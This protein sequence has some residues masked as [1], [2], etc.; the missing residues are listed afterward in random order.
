MFIMP[1]M[2]MSPSAA[3]QQEGAVG[4]EL[5]EDAG[6]QPTSHPSDARLLERSG[7]AAAVAGRPPRTCYQ[8]FLPNIVK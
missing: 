3:E 7:L 8:R 5:V 2:T 4:A 6:D 1:R